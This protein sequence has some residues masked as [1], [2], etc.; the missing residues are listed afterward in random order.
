MYRIAALSKQGWSRG[1]ESASPSE[2]YP[3][4][5]R[6]SLVGH[7]DRPHRSEPMLVLK[8]P[9]GASAAPAAE[10][11]GDLLFA[12]PP[13]LHQ[14]TPSWLA[15]APAAA[16]LLASRA[17]APPG[18]PGSSLRRSASTGTP[19]STRRRSGLARWGQWLRR[20]CS[21]GALSGA[22][23]RGRSASSSQSSSGSAAAARDAPKL[24]VRVRSLTSIK[25][26]LTFD[27]GGGAARHVGGAASAGAIGS[28]GGGGL[29]TLGRT[30]ATE[31]HTG[32]PDVRSE[33]FPA[34]GDAEEDGGHWDPGLDIDGEDADTVAAAGGSSSGRLSGLSGGASGDGSSAGGARRRVIESPGS[35]E[36]CAAAA[37]DSHD[38]GC[39]AA[40]GCGGGEGAEPLDWR[41]GAVLIPGAA[42][43]RGGEGGVAML[44]S[45]SPPRGGAL[46]RCAARPR[47]ASWPGTLC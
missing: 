30:A 40:I 42:A 15:T 44:G 16:V 27:S 19:D 24:S 3:W 21:N 22:C 31:L 4:V 39:G 33:A 29:R 36:S 47:S 12:S 7:G 5:P 17:A 34:W 11:E 43:R 14:R 6:G 45:D 8:P 41:C 10:G 23:V 25:D 37:Q 13:N 1:G 32:S 28:G 35:C 26:M 46:A 38:Y 9:F 2:L 20:R 18:K